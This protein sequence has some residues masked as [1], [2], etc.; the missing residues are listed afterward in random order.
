MCGMY[1][2]PEMMDVVI[3]CCAEKLFYKRELT[4]STECEKCYRN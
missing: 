2:R 1:K 4:I 3:S